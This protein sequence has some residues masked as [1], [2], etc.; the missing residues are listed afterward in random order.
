M[1]VVIGLTNPSFWSGIGEDA[2]VTDGQYTDN[3]YSDST[4]ASKFQHIHLQC[5]ECRVV[6]HDPL[7]FD[8][9]H[10]LIDDKAWLCEFSPQLRQEPF[11]AVADIW[12]DS[13]EEKPAG[14]CK[15]LEGLVR[16]IEGRIELLDIKPWCAI[17]LEQS[18]IEVVVVPHRQHVLRVFK[19][20]AHISFVGVVEEDERAIFS[21]RVGEL[22]KHF[23]LHA[24]KSKI[25]KHV[26]TDDEFILLLTEAHVLDLL[27]PEPTGCLKKPDRWIR[28][29]DVHPLGVLHREGDVAIMSADIEHP[30]SLF[31]A[32]MSLDDFDE[33]FVL[34]CNELELPILG[35][36]FR[37]PRFLDHVM[38]MDRAFSGSHKLPLVVMD[39][40]NN[41]IQ[42]LPS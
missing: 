29:D 37:H 18:F 42:L 23:S 34:L 33:F 6:I 40:L 11:S 9:E 35:C 1:Q 39:H 4:I 7:L 28:I 27:V 30:V 10:T 21:E 14:P 5:L 32:D 24:L 13:A 41:I 25:A 17:G 3:D 20:A 31:E 12:V 22:L 19:Q 36:P 16:Y 15:C 26:A 38:R 2:V 8:D